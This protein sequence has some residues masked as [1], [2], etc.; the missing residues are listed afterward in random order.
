[1]IDA[2]TFIKVIFFYCSTFSG[3]KQGNNYSFAVIFKFMDGLLI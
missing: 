1:M 2:P 3:K